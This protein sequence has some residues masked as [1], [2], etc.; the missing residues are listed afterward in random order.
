M[1]ERYIA[2]SSLAAARGFWRMV[3]LTFG[4]KLTIYIRRLLLSVKSSK[5]MTVNRKSWTGPN[6]LST[7]SIVGGDAPT[8]PV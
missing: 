5:K 7:F 6:T 8:G 1:E 2:Y 3:G 4:R